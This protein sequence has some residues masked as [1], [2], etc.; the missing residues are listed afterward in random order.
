MAIWRL[1]GAHLSCKTLIKYES[2]KTNPDIKDERVKSVLMCVD[3]LNYRVGNSLS[4]DLI[5]GTS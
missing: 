5:F 2:L 4:S 3:F 1:N